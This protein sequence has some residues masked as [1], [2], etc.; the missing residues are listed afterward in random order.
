MSE[1]FQPIANVAPKGVKGKML[2]YG[3]LLADFFQV[4]TV[5]RDIGV[6]DNPL[7]YTIRLLK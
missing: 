4:I 7:G 2:F 1:F 5:F 3:R 6:S